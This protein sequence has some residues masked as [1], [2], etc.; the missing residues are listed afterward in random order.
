MLESQVEHVST[1]AWAFAFALLAGLHA[2]TMLAVI[3]LPGRAGVK[4]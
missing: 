3:G 1:N 2:L 4:A